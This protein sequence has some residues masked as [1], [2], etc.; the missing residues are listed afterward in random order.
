MIY[1]PVTNFGTHPLCTCKIGTL[2]HKYRT[3]NDKMF[4]ERA[5]ENLPNFTC[6]H[7]RWTKKYFGYFDGPQIINPLTTHN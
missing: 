4:A 1:I 3:H 2:D 6:G 5:C 7:I